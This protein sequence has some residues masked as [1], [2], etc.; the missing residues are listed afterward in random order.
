MV[1]GERRDAQ[2]P[3]G[4]AARHVDLGQPADGL[5][6]RQAADGAGGFEGDPLVAGGVERLLGARGQG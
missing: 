1:G 3:G 2:A 5:G 4:V 6:D